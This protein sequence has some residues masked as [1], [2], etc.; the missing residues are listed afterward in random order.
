MRKIQVLAA[1]FTVVMMCFGGCLDDSEDGETNR[2][3]EA[4]ILM[5]R[6]ASVMEAGEPFQIDGSAS[7]D[8]DGD[9]LQYMWTLSGLGSPTDLSTKMSDLVTVDT[10]GNDLVL[11]LMVRDSGGLTSQDIVVI[12]VEPGNRPPIAT[13]TTPSNGGAYS[14]GKEVAFNGMASSDPDNDI[15]SYNWDLGDADGPTYPASKQSKFEMELDEGD[16]RVTLT[17]ED[18]D[19]ESNSVTHSFSVTNLPPIASIK[20]D[21]NS[22]FTL[23]LIHI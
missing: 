11:T 15:L 20:V 9:E 6:Q 1:T 4:L 23:S 21:T 18:P 19:G 8:P 2:A 5:P 14:E 10:P 12:S 7:T 17:V 16:Y 22:V 3:P 13:I